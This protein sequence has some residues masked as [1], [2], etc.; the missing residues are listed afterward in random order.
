MLLNDRKYEFYMEKNTIQD[1]MDK[2]NY[3]YPALVVKVNNQ[4]IDRKDFDEF[5][6]QENDDLKIYHLI[7]GG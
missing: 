6:V 5:V 3:I 1:I 7:A 2:M 4:L